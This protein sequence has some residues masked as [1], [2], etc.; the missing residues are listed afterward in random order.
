MIYQKFSHSLYRVSV[1]LIACPAPIITVSNTT[2]ESATISWAADGE[3]YTL[4]YK[5]YGETEYIEEAIE[6]EGNTYDIENLSPAS[7]YQV[8]VQAN[9]GEE[10]GLSQWGSFVFNTA[11]SEE[12]ISEFPWVEGFETPWTASSVLGTSAPNCWAVYNGGYTSSGYN[13]NWQWQNSTYYAHGGEGAATCYTDYASGNHND[14]LVTP[15]LT[16]DNNKQL[17]FLARRANNTTDEPEEISIWIS[18]ED[19]ELSAPTSTSDPLPGFTQIFQTDIPQGDFQLYEVSLAE[20]SGN[21]YIAFVRRNAPNDGYWLCLDDVTVRDIPMC[22]RPTNLATLE[23]TET[24]ATISWEGDADSYNLYYKNASLNDGYTLIENVT[25]DDGIYVLEDLSNSSSYKWYVAAVCDGQEVSTLDTGFISTTCNAVTDFPWTEGFEV[26]WVPSSVLSEVNTPL[27]WSVYDGGVVGTGSTP[28]RWQWQSS[29]SHSGSG[30]AGCYTDYANS[31][32]NDWLITPLLVLDDNKQLSFYAQRA[33][34]STNEPEEISIWISDED[35][36][37]SAPTSTSDPLPGFTQIFQTDI[38]QGD[39]QLYEIPLTEYSGNRYIAFVR[40]NS[41][42][43]GYWLRLDDVKVDDMP[44]CSRPVVTSAT[45]SST[46]VTLTWT[47]T[48]EDFVV[49][50]GTSANN[51]TTITMQDEL[52]QMT[53]EDGTW[54]VTIT[55]LNAKQLIITK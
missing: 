31:N 27:C 42:H 21:R 33:H 29:N 13:Y 18:D 14:W 35:I 39:Y 4:R 36:E 23:T 10:D 53:D 45:P 20:Y 1:T 30:N 49:T 17:G 26:N 44:T 22:S 32:H 19:I 5:L 24:T 37:L 11:C 3:T 43:D 55:G 28:Y 38:P 12:G 9:C 50:Y 41:P 25:L 51:L 15:L 6:V 46:S 48:G 8:E 47:S 2:T 34:N 7:A 52:I 16:L 40:R 54:T